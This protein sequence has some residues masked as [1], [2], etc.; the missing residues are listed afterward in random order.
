MKQDISPELLI[1]IPD[2]KIWKAE[3]EQIAKQL[4]E[5]N[6]M[7][8]E[9]EEAIFIT[10]AIGDPDLQQDYIMFPEVD[11]EDSSS[12]GSEESELYNSSHDYSWNRR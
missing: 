11:Y 10:D 12:L 1:S 9:E 5:Q 7:Q 6:Q 3:Q 8:E 4:E 2:P